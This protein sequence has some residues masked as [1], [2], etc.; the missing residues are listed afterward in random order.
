MKTFMATT[1]EQ[2]THLIELGLD[3]DTADMCWTNHYFDSMMSYTRL[4]STKPSKYKEM[5]DYFHVHG[6]FIEPAWS[7][8]ALLD[9]M[10][11]INN[12]LPDL[13]KC[14]DG[15]CVAYSDKITRDADSQWQDGKT[16][17]EAAYKM[18]CWLFERG[19]IKN[20]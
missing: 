16:P 12:Q 8:T 9:M 19:Y 10:P 5:L 15:Y 20:K 3:P 17:V 2:S 18:M 14:I 11:E 13:R 4:E 7:L 6:P 1:Q